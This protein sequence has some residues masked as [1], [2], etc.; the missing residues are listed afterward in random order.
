MLIYFVD[1]IFVE[2]R[3]RDSIFPIDKRVVWNILLF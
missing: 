2:N 3:I 1:N